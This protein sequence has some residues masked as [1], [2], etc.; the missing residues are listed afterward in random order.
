[1][2]KILLIILGLVFTFYANAQVSCNQGDQDPNN[3]VPKPYPGDNYDP[4]GKLS[5]DPNDIIGPAG[6]DSVRWV[7][8]KDILN[9]TILFENSE[10]FATAAAQMVDVRF[11]FQSKAL[12][13]GFGIGTY[14]FSNMSYNVEN[15]PNAYQNRID[16][17]DSLGI[18][19]DVIGGLD[20][21]KNQAFWTFSTIDPATGYAPWEHD[22]GL[23][24][25]NDSTHVGE[26][27]VTFSLRPLATMQT[28]DTISIQANI[29]F[30]E[31]DTIPTNRWCNK[32]D[33]GNPQSKV[34]GEPILSPTGEGQGGASYSLSF[35]AKDDENGSGVKS[36]TLFL[37]NSAG[38]Y[39]EYGTYAPDSIVTF[40]TE[41][42]K[43][44]KLFSLAIDNT[45]NMEPLK[46]APDLIVNFN[47][48]PTDIALSD[49]I[50]NDDIE[51]KGF[52]GELSTTDS[53]D[54]VKFTY[55]LAEGE[56]AIH[57]D[58][59]QIDGAQLKAKECF[60]C[61]EDSVFSVRISTTDE[62]GLSFSKAFTL[63]MNRVLERPQPD[64]LNV[65]I[66]EGDVYDFHGKEITETGQY[67]Y[68][69]S[70]DYMCDSV[71]V[72]NL[73]INA[74]PQA[75]TV[76][77]HNDQV[78]VSSIERNNQWFKDGEKIEGATDI[79]FTP[80]ETGTYYVCQS[81]GSCYSQPS[82]KFYANFDTTVDFTLPLIEGWTWMSSNLVAKQDPKQLLAPITDNVEH[83]VG[84]N[85]ELVNDPLYGLTGT[86]TKVE[87][88]EA[89]KIKVNAATELD[90]SGQI[91]LP[92]EISQPIQKGWTWI[93]Y[94]PTIDIA[95]ED[96]LAN[97][98]PV[99]NDVIK[100]Q[101]NFAAFVGGKWTGTLT[102][103]KHGEGYMYYSAAKKEFNYPFSRITKVVD[104]DNATH[105]KV[106]SVSPWTVD[107][108]KYPDNMT[109]IAQVVGNGNV[110]P[111]GAY[112]I[113]AFVGDECRGISQYVDDRLFITI[114]GQA[115][116]GK[117][118]FKAYENVTGNELAVQ[119]AV[120]YRED[121]VGTYTKPKLLNVADATGIDAVETDNFNIYPNPVRNTLYI[122][123][124]VKDIKSVRIIALSGAIINADT[125]Y[126]AE[127]GLNVSYLVDGNYIL[128]IVTD[129][130]VVYKRFIKVY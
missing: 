124:N 105:I 99:E 69:K 51:A 130:G 101:S 52:I 32:I 56:G 12:Q 16:L 60:K 111:V 83:F 25:V 8:I 19:V 34:T 50:F 102:T 71:Y 86:L 80:T 38:I 4:D 59:F 73:Q 10:E 129:K 76:T 20:V 46:E 45:G 54:E 114:H 55:A 125:Q 47:Q 106:Y 28:G 100:G 115:S 57:N 85:N 14:C 94:V 91:Y 70:N 43:Q 103:L 66:C 118:S 82:E 37:A 15:S 7:S 29:V 6:Y 65:A 39:E 62:G 74:L 88:T 42:G 26:G 31:N 21:T 22:K 1:M 97:L 5:Y 64:T 107:G 110:A 121:N 49:T 87:P 93:G 81:N 72:L 79:T 77:V 89:Y 127:K 24:Q 67:F 104:T 63:N 30:D 108:H 48:A 116:D 120:S 112:T 23:L 18:Y 109:M 96:A 68:T 122:N 98:N 119:E 13:K 128:G 53:E 35:T 9:Y 95:I 33:A 126:N 44:Y 123:G 36:V 40:P 2:E 61:A 84:I 78:L 113:G 3:P 11:D 58:M 92:T 17:R 27:F 75:P 117:V 41:A 90:L